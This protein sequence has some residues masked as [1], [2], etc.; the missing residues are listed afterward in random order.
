MEL[1]VEILY[2]PSDLGSCPDV[3]QNFISNIWDNS[4]SNFDKNHKLPDLFDET[5]HPQVIER[6]QEFGAIFLDLPIDSKIEITINPNVSYKICRTTY[7]CH[8]V[9][10]PNHNEYLAFLLR[11]A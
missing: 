7:A 4:D 8:Q 5:A 10:F 3:W 1:A 2:L 9:L 6:L 11:W